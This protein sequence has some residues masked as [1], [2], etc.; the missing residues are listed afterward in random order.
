MYKEVWI[1]QLPSKTLL[2]WKD[3]LPVF[4]S[5]KNPYLVVAN[6]FIPCIQ[7]CIFAVLFPF[8]KQSYK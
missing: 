3:Y 1:Q 5:I 8:F 4:Y 7:N 6:H 2:A